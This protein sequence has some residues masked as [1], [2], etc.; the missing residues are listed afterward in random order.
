[1]PTDAAMANDFNFVYM[2]KTVVPV[3]VAIWKGNS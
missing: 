1:M 2:K 3:L